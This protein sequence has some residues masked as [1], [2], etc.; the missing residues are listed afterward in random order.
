MQNGRLQGLTI[1][2][3]LSLG[4]APARAQIGVDGEAGYRTLA[5]S[6]SAT[7]VFGSSSGLTLGGSLQYAFGKG[8]FVRAGLRSFSKKGERVF[9]ADA[10]STP[11]PLGF[12]LEASITSIDIL[13]GWRFKL[14]GKKPSRFAP[15]AAVGLELA[16]YREES[17]VA[18]LVETSDA[19]KA[20]FQM[21]GGLEYRVHGGLSVAAEVGYSLVPSA[22]GVGGVSKIYGEDDIGGFRVVGRL[23]YRFSTAKKPR[24]AP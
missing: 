9:L 18:G 16:S 13:A 21:V 5:A 17:T 24:K 20:G 6:N 14:G 19:S 11:F 22:L 4:A 15:Y 12:P 8:L 10:T 3:A 2:L 1:A 23:G 7:A